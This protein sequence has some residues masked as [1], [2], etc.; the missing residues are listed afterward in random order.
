MTALADSKDP[1]ESYLYSGDPV[2]DNNTREH[3]VAKYDQMHR[4]AYDAQGRVVLY[5]GADNWPLAIP[6]TKEDKGW[7]F[8]SEAGEK[9]LLFRRIGRNELFTIDVLADLATA[10]QEYASEISSNGGVK[11][12]AQKV[13]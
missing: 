10:Q 13:E 5:I 2:E 11:Q 8:D 9:E 3:F 7:R 12:F 1:L 6:L 4:V